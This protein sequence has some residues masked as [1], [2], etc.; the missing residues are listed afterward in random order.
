M[1]IPMRT[2][3]DMTL[4]N[5]VDEKNHEGKLECSYDSRTTAKTKNL[6]TKNCVNEND[7]TIFCIIIMFSIILPQAPRGQSVS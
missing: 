2:N 3:T 6:G 4:K 5:C 1:L 7:I